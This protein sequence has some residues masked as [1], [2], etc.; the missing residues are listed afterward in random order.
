[1]FCRAIT[2]PFARRGLYP[3]GATGKRRTSHEGRDLVVGQRREDGLRQLPGRVGTELDRH[4]LGA[5]PYVDA[6]RVIEGRVL[7]VVEVHDGAVDRE[8]LVAEVTAP[9]HRG[10]GRDVGA[11]LRPP[12]GERRRS[13]RPASTRPS[14]RRRG[15]T[16]G[17]RRR[18]RA[19]RLRRSGSRTSW[20]VLRAP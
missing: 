1:G 2:P 13:S 5:A 8:P 11:H 14:P 9:G 6:Q 12:S 16:D 18:T 3:S 4:S 20:R 7:R 10:G 15:T 17:P 19:R